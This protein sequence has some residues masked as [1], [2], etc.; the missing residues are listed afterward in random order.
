MIH[1]IMFLQERGVTVGQKPISQLQI[2][3]YPDNI[4]SNK[5]ARKY[6]KQAPQLLLET[7]DGQPRNLYKAEIPYYEPEI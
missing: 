5:I 6:F 2:T 1:F 3:A 7:C 4:A